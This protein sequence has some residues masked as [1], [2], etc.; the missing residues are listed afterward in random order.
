[1]SVVESWQQTLP[2]RIDHSGVGPAP[3]FDLPAWSNCN[4]TIGEYRDRLSLRLRRIDRPDMRILDDEIRGGLSL[5]ED[6]ERAR[7][8]NAKLQ[9]TLLHILSR[10]IPVRS[11][12][13]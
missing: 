12:S 11:L 8:N 4:D 3:S 1:V 13:N 9:G 10:S 6:A 7:E 5:P 2:G